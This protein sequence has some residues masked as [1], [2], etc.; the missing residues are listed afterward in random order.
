MFLGNCCFGG[1][2][3]NNF[4][5]G[6]ISLVKASVIIAREKSTQDVLAE[7]NELM[8]ENFPY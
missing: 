2:N 5:E 3:R 8:I 6:G 7:V 4:C 1:C